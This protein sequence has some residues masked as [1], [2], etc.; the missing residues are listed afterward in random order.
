[1]DRNKD[2]YCASLLMYS[3]SELLYKHDEE[4][5]NFLLEKTKDYINQIEINADLIKEVKDYAAEIEKS[6]DQTETIQQ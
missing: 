4:F 6:I 5:S 3:A 1:M 2:I